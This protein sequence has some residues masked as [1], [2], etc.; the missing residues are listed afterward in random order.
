MNSKKDN[1]VM[2]AFFDLAMQMEPERLYCDGERSKKDAMAALAIIKK[3]WAKLEA[4]V[5]VKVT[6]EEAAAYGWNKNR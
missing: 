3:T 6:V 1:D 2:D 5:G 4:K